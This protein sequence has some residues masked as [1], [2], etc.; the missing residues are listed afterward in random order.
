MLLYQLWIC[1]SEV[2][3]NSADYV[4]SKQRSNSV[5]RD[6]WL[7]FQNRSVPESD[8]SFLRPSLPVDSGADCVHIDQ[9][10]PDFGVGV[11]CTMSDTCFSSGLE[12]GAVIR[13]QGVFTRRKQ[14]EMYS[15]S[16]L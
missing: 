14:A 11:H 1:R 13:T 7:P 3:T 2:E 9:T 6:D 5:L 15:E 4:A 16:L 8:A 10:E 12:H